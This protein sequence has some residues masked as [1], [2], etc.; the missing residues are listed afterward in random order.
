MKKYKVIAF[1]I[2]VG[3]HEL[4]GHGCGKVFRIDNAGKLNFD[5]TTVKNPL[6][7]E[8]I[9]MWYEPG[10]SYDSKFGKIGKSLEECRA[11]TVALY[12][13]LNRDVVKLFGYTDAQEIDDIIYVGWLLII[14][15]GVAESL[16]SYNLSNRQWGQAHRQARFVIMR[17][18]LEAGQ[19]LIT[20]EETEKDK[21]LLLT[22]DRTKIET[23]GKAAIRELLLKIQVCRSTGDVVGATKLYNHYSEV[24]DSGTHPW[25]KWQ[26]IVL[27]HIKPRKLLTQANTERKGKNRMSS[28][29]NIY[30]DCYYSVLF[31]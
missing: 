8:P 21:H 4:F 23:V 11:E 31:L 16:Q 13:G 28:K 5:R 19:G 24:N 27:M 30:M 6:T 9:D 18:L 12:L 15:I 10:E 26:K 14:W 20:V 25:A 7:G 17:A 22:V 29:K 2:Q 1:E 3:L